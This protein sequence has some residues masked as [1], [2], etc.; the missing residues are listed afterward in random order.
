MNATE[1]RQTL[2]RMDVVFGLPYRIDPQLIAE[3]AQRSF[4]DISWFDADQ[5]ITRMGEAGDKRPSPTRLAFL[6][7]GIAAEKR[8]RMRVAPV[9]AVGGPPRPPKCPSCQD[10]YFAAG[11][12]MPN[13][14]V[15]GRLRCLC[16]Q[17]SARWQTDDAMAYVDP[18]LPAPN[19]YD[20]RAIDG[21]Q[22]PIP[23]PR[24][25]PMP[26]RAEPTLRRLTGDAA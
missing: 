17:A 21:A 3:E 26:L 18:Q 19:R 23:A 8:A 24:A 10:A 20:P 4:L 11:F 16:R 15:I 25:L 12:E 6:A 7:R 13:G 9:E 5:A 22:D 14:H 2:A 1:I